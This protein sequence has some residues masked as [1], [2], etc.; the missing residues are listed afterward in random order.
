[1]SDPET[2]THQHMTDA[3]DGYEAKLRTVLEHFSDSDVTLAEAKLIAL[4]AD[5]PRNLVGLA[6]ARGV[7]KQA[8]QV[9][10]KSLA[11]R[12]LVTMSADKS[13]A[14]IRLVSLTEAGQS[15]ND[16]FNRAHAEVEALIEAKLGPQRLKN[17]RNMLGQVVA[18]TR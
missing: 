16:A 4:V 2:T 10:I 6:A 15:V 14:R 9:Q 8:V 5:A 17:F 3:L 13:D 7:S 18:A 11:E 12:G 1:M